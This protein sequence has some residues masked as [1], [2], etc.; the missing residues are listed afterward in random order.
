MEPMDREHDEAL[1][2]EGL[3]EA[4]RQ[5][6]DSLPQERIPPAGLEERT[7]RALEQRGLIRR[8][9]PRWAS[10]RPWIAVAGVAAGVALFAVGLAV[11]QSMGARQTA[12]ALAAVYPDATDRAAAR[13]Q[14]TGSEHVQALYALVEAMAAA[15][16]AEREQAREVARATLWAAA[17]EVVRLAPDDPLAERILEEIER[18]RLGTAGG[19][20]A[21]HSVIWF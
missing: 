17:S 5:A 4:E 19:R 21:A 18:A 20:E 14:S 7:V 13:V 12:E 16:P 10:S 3:S 2:R 11:G 6:F 15:A 8:R 9:R 1:D